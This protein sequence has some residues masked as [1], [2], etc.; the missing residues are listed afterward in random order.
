MGLKYDESLKIEVEALIKMKSSCQMTQEN[1]KLVFFIWGQTDPVIMLSAFTYDILKSN[2]NQEFF[3]SYYQAL[4]KL[5]AN[6]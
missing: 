3:E 1:I 2:P 4:S 5:Y 6:R